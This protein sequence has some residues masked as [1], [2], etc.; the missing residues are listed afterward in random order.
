MK[1]KKKTEHALTFEQTMERMREKDKKL[2]A[3]RLVLRIALIAATIY[4]V[5]FCDVIAALGWISSAQDG[6]NWPLHF[7]NYGYGMIFAAAVITAGTILCLC[8]LNR[9][10]IAFSVTGTAIALVIMQLVVNYAND[11]GFYSTIR[12]MPAGTVYQNAIFPTAIVC[13]ILIA[14]ALMQF[15][16]MESTLKRREK[17]LQENAPAPKII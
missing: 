2:K 17:K 13:V 1:N 8:G 11:A 15:F 9:I 16:S 12:D 5:L 7:V 14:L 6:E 10:A 4:F 3:V